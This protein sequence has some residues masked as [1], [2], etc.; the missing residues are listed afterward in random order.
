MAVMEGV[1]EYSEGYEVELLQTKGNGR[2]VI[3][4][5][6]QGGFDSTSVDVINL[7]AWLRANRPEL[8]TPADS[9]NRL[10]PN[11]G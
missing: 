2:W 8:L 6:N 7:I 3:M 1:T 9:E 5:V 10:L 11:R 4:A